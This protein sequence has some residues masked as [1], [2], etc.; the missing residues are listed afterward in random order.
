M[1]SKNKKLELLRSG[2]MALQ[3]KVLSMALKGDISAIK[4]VAD[5]IWPRLRPQAET[6]NVKTKSSEI[7][8]Q[9]QKIIDT[10]LAGQLPVDALRDLLSALADQA[11]LVEFSEIDNRLKVLEEHRDSPPWGT[12][13]NPV[14]LVAD[15]KK[16]PI[17]GKRRRLKT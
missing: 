17:R 16:L 13:P 2:D 4:I 8:E 11:R 15:Q 14:E 10:A 6:V 1:G 9:G 7:V 3:K 5:R 12:H